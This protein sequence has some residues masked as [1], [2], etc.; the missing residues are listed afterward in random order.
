MRLKSLE[1]NGFK[2]FVDKTALDFETGITGVVGPNGCGKSNIVDAIRWAMGEQ[3]PR[4]LRGRGMEDVIFGGAE[5]ISPVG[6]AEVVITFDNSEGGGP[7]AFSAYNEIQVARRLYR[8]GESEYLLN[9]T[10]CRLRDIQDFFRD[11]GIGA[12]GYTIVEQGRIA[13]IVSAKAEERRSLIEE[14]AGIGKY[15]AR[16]REAET[17]IASTEQNLLRVTD[18]LGEIRRQIGSIERQAKKAARYKRMRETLRVL[19]LSLAVDDRAELTSQ[20][21]ASQAR[22]TLLRDAVTA[23]ETQLSERELA[24]E[25]KRIELAECEKVLAAGS[26]R[27]LALRTDIKECEAQ[28]EYGRREREQLA[29]TIAARNEELERLRE[30]LRQQEVEAESV[31]A[32]LAAVESAVA[33][34]RDPLQSAEAEVLAAREKLAEIER[35]R[36]VANQALVDVLTGI[37][38]SEDRKATV[39]D[40]GAELSTRMRD[41]DEGLEVGQTEASRADSEQR[42]LEEGLRNLLAERDRFMGLQRKALENHA[43]AV[44]RAREAAE[45]QRSAREVRETRRARLA[46]LKEVVERRDDVGSGARHLLSRD[47]SERR[48]LG[49]KGLVRDALEVD[50]DV[51]RAVEAVLADRAGALVVDRPEGALSALDLLRSANSGRG[52]FVALPSPSMEPSGFVPFGEPL[53]GRVR[54]RDGFEPLAHRLLGNANLVSSLDEVLKHYG[55]GRIPCTFVTKAGDVLTPDGVVAGGGAA[56]GEAGGLIAHVREIRELETEV[57]SLEAQVARCETDHATAEAAL[58]SAADELENLRNRHHTAAL[59]VA[60]HEKDLERTRERVKALGEA[61]EGRVAERSGILAESESRAVEG[62]LLETQLSEARQQRVQ[63][64]RDLDALGLRIGSAGREVARLETV[65]TERRVEQAG[66]EDQCNRLRAAS[67]RAVAATREAGEWIARREEEIRSA[68]ARRAELA[69]IIESAQS[70]LD[71]RLRAEELARASTDEKRDVFERMSTEVGALDEASRELRSELTE[72]R[73]EVGQAELAARET[74]LNLSHLDEAIREKWDTNLAT[75]TLPPLEPEESEAAPPTPEASETERAA[76]SATEEPGGSDSELGSADSDE[77]EPAPDAAREARRNAELARGPREERAQRLEELRKKVQ[78]L[79]DVNLGAIEEHEELSERFR[80]L[81]E[82]KVDLDATLE[83][84]RD[85]IARINRT[86]RRRFREAFEQI[87]QRFSENFPRLFRG[88]KASLSLTDTEDVLEAG[89]EI[90][91]MPPGKRL[92]NVNLLS[93]GEKTL[94]AVALLVAVFQVRPSPFFLLDEVDAALDDANI[95]RFNEIVK[96]LAATSQFVLI[97]H[98]KHTIEIAD[99]LYGVTMER[100]GVSKLVS[101]EVH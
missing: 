75:W 85:A 4:R 72:R 65:A 39:E 40:R 8:T 90:M 31:Q 101:V 36:E 29:E 55:S 84:L 80:F 18:V 62:G 19:E 44:R 73:E 46:S 82:Q 94:T 25:A 27:L 69:T 88:G 16:R 52:V 77:E 41:A 58:V 13:E 50:R 10:A 48:S 24:T 76:A 47:E 54:P 93:G 3:S 30:N 81:T 74:E 33:T 79:G 5:G 9:K 61:H 49:L 34:E 11:T 45:R 1:L 6:M 56:E 17:K 38:R 64:Q 67:E 53:L 95:G 98:N 83:L 78:Q 66:R 99:L 63:R 23:L 91:A 21:E 100:K 43:Q 12:K 92:Q 20:I 42:S 87:S 60:N 22:L 71:E 51:E 7:P 57:A 86:S 14:A 32:D 15:K 96:E 97:T 70:T 28:I 59:A 37:A 26:E 2:S 68:E 35:E 89:I